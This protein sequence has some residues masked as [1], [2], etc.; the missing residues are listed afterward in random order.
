MVVFSR[1]V[2]HQGGLLLGV[3]HTTKQAA[4]NQKAGK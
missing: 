3:H 1:M 4:E 2:F